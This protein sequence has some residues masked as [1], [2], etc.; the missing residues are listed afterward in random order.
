MP[1]PN[2]LAVAGLLLWLG[3][4]ILLRRRTDSAILSP[5]DG[6]TDRGST[7]VL[8]I[9]YA[10]AFVLIVGL[11]AVGVGRLPIGARWI[12][13]AM[14]ATGLGLR[15]WGMTVLGR[16]YTR[17][18]R[19]VGDHQVVTAGPYRLIRHPGYAGSLLVWTGYCVGSGNWIALI[20]VAAVMLAAYGW[21]I[22]SEE[23][24]LADAFGTEYTSYQLRTARLVPFV[25]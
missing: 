5:Q 7:V 22:R 20:V 2:W 4:E 3:Y 8:I 10:L 11:G 1:I 17:T 15:A 25:Y 18:L 24:L 16:F 9:A 6:S 14:M 13:V 12:G 23:R 19:I 21:R